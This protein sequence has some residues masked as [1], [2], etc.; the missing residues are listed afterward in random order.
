MIILLYDE[1]TQPPC[2]QSRGA[3][4]TVFIFDKLRSYQQ[5]IAMLSDI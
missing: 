3:D 1:I 2:D 4:W 5:L